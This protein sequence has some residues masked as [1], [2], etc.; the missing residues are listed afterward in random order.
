[1]PIILLTLFALYLVAS[2]YYYKESN[3]ALS[4]KFFAS[5]ILLVLFLVSLRF[6]QTMLAA[7][8]AVLLFLFGILRNVLFNNYFLFL[9]GQKILSLVGRN[10]SCNVGASQNENMSK[11]EAAEILGVKVDASKKEILFQYKE[12]MKRNHPDKGG[13]KKIAILLNQAKEVLLK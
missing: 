5:F 6:G 11:A 13:S 1:M 3:P 8:G 2:T 7:V 12:L 10:K 4:R 9:L